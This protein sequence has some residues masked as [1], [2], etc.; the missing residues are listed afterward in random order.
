VGDHRFGAL[1]GMELF[2]SDNRSDVGEVHASQC[3][4]YDFESSGALMFWI[5]VISLLFA[6]GALL[7]QAATFLKVSF[8]A[9]Q[10]TERVNTLR[11]DVDE[12]QREFRQGRA[13]AAAAGD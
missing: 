13:Q 1:A 3:C 12:L 2:H 10:F 8:L 4:W 9:G 11:K 5:S 6:F 7:L